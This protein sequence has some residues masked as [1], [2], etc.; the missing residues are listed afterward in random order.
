M[1]RSPG[2]N[3]RKQEFEIEVE[4]SIKVESGARKAPQLGRFRVVCR[5]CCCTGVGGRRSGEPG[6]WAHHPLEHRFGVRRDRL[7]V[8]DDRAQVQNDLIGLT[9][10]SLRG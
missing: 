7:R 6:G 9:E 2:Q 4:A 10:M 1:E 5:N 3:K 8:P